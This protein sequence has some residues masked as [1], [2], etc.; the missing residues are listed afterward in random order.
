MPGSTRS[1]ISIAL[2]A[3]SGVAVLGPEIVPDVM[4]GIGRHVEAFAPGGRQQLR[5]AE[6][7]VGDLQTQPLAPRT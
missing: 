3:R 1:C 2:L 5:A 4:L 7:H 6:A